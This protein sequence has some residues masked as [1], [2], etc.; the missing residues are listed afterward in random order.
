MGL[1]K[2]VKRLAKKLYDLNV[3]YETGET[4][5]PDVAVLQLGSCVVEGVAKAIHKAV[6][7][8]RG[9]QSEKH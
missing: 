8:S 7:K 2:L 9:K 6:R 5:S 1:K 3:K 4:F